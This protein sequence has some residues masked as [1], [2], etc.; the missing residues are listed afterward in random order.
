MR[1][2]SHTDAQRREVL[3]GNIAETVS[4]FYMGEHEGFHLGY[5]VERAMQAIEAGICEQ[6]GSEHWIY[7]RIAVEPRNRSRMIVFDIAGSI[8]ESNSAAPISQWWW[9]NKWDPLG[10]AVRLRMQVPFDRKCEAEREVSLRLR[11]RGLEFSVLR[12]EPELRLFGGA[13]GIRIAHELFAYDSGFLVSWARQSDPQRGPMIPP[14]LSLALMIDLARGTGLDLFELWDL[15]DRLAAKR[16]ISDDPVSL[17]CRDLATRVIAAGPDALFAFY[18]GEQQR[19]LSSYRA[20]LRQ[21]AER[22]SRA[23][24]Q[25]DLECGLRGSLVPM[26]LFHWNRVGLPSIAQAALSHSAADEFARRSRKGTE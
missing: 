5:V 13:E 4:R 26:I 11:Q 22:L 17:K 8:A 18:D 25:G 2:C 24:F 12:Y 16:V 20:R 15:F 21:C 23:Y 10:S 14:G 19:L 6:D 7:F 9:L 3:A 1:V